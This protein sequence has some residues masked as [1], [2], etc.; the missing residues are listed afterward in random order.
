MICISCGRTHRYIAS[1][2]DQGMH[3]LRSDDAVGLGICSFCE[4]SVPAWDQGA[5]DVRTLAIAKVSNKRETD[6]PGWLIENAKIPSL[7][8]V[9][10]EIYKELESDTAGIERMIELIQTDPG[11]T[12]RSLQLGNSAYYGSSK[13]ITQV[14]DAILRVGPFDLWALLISTEV[15]SLFF[16]IRPDLLD[17]NI[18]WRHSL[19]TACACRKLAEQQGIGSPGDLFIAGL[20]HDVGKLVFLQQM[21][22]EYADVV[23]SH[24]FGDDCSQ[25]EERLLSVNHAEIGAKLF[26][27]WN[28]PERL[29]QLT[30]EHHSADADD[31]DVMLLR[32]A[33]GLAH[34]YLDRQSSDA[35]QEGEQ[36]VDMGP[37]IA[38][39]ERLTELVL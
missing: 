1:S 10:I 28:F 20:I 30:A 23:A 37:I 16:G 38:L 26:E 9:L 2:I 25:L 34:H 19:L 13:Q 27:S 12:A 15:K 35:D 17:M 18:F 3:W 22:I 21:P 32:Q 39:Y 4:D 33:N 8:H 5:R 29:I 24:T 7:P 31:P 11:L 14:A 6:L 36:Q